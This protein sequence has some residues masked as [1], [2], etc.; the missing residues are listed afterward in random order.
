[1]AN[2]GSG[3]NGFR[4]IT[5][6]VVAGLLAVLAT[7]EGVNHVIEDSV[8]PHRMQSLAHAAVGIA[9]I[10]GLA[11]QLGRRPVAG[12]LHLLAAIAVAA[13]VADLLGQ[14][15]GGLEV[16][17]AVAYGLLLA[18]V[19]DRRAVLRHGPASRPMIAAGVVTLVAVAPYTLRES[20]L[21]RG[22]HEEFGYWT[23]T[24][25]TVLVITLAVI[26]AGLRVDGWR[27]PAAFA[28]VALAACGA[29]SIALPHE[30][31]SFGTVFGAIGMAGA[32]AL[33][34]LIVRDARSVRASTLAA[35]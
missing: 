4:S 10:A 23:W 34:G 32:V 7:V 24:T 16:I 6:R 3:S 12:G 13:T 20:A 2:N 17:A 22:S 25:T 14:R 28:V 18:I 19:P 30:T 1:M 31:S 9:L 15:F 29:L 26:L 11:A 8:A 27:L 21:Q 5:Y 35:A 33:A